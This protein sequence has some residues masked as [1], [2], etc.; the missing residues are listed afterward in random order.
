MQGSYQMVADDGQAFDAPIAPFRLAMPACSSKRGG[1]WHAL[2][3]AMCRAVPASLRA[4]LALLKFSA[5]RDQLWFVGDLVNRGPQ[6]LQ[7]LRL[8][9]ALGDN[10]VVVLGNH[11]L[12][13]LR[14]PSLK[15]ARQTRRHAARTAARARSDGAGC[16][17]CWSGRW[18]I[19]T[20]CMASFW[21][22]AGLVPQWS[23]SRTLSLA[24][25]VQTALV[26]APSS[27]WITCMGISP[28]SG[29]MSCR[30]MTGCDLS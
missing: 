15:V 11:D 7:C 27:S 21:I 29:A 20:R 13:L 23:V 28:S 9:H 2:P 18:H 10:A 12:H 26:A 4:L 25:E 8:I 6:S 3:S 22:H 19:R 17:G 5:D 16:N 14:S 30:A 24:Q 1:P